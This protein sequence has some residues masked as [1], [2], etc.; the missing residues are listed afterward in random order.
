[1][2]IENYRLENK[3]FIKIKQITEQIGKLQRFFPQFAEAFPSLLEE[4]QD[5]EFRKEI[6]D[7]VDKV[8]N[9]FGEVKS[10]AS[11]TLKTLR[12]EIQH[13]RK[14][15]DE[16]FNR[17]LSSNSDFLEDIRESIIDDQR[18]LAVKS[19]F[20]KRVAGRVLGISKTGSITYIQPESVVKHYLKLRENQEEEKK[21]STRYYGH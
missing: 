6:I 18:V 11:A 5:L 19:G 20:K 17:S 16:N 14:A 21:K 10:E 4:V 1:M 3:S 15:I 8:F 7:K 9:R 12:T 2:H 13:A